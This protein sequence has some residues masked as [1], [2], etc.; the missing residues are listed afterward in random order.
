MALAITTKLGTHILCSSRSACID[1]QVKG[2][3]HKVM[4][5]VVAAWLLVTRGAAVVRCCCCQ[6]GS[7][8]RYDCT[9]L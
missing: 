2:Q 8:C 4:K 1:P 6:R 3:D 9:F 7:A 5:T